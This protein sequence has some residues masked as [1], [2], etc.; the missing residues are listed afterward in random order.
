MKAYEITTRGID[1]LKLSE[2]QPA[3]LGARQVRVRIKASSLN[4][5]DLM[6]VLFGGMGGKLPLIPNSDG[7][8]E[9]IET[10]SEVTRCKTGDRVITT[11]FQH[12]LDGKITA[13][14]MQSALGG[15]LDGVLA[16]EIVVDEPGVVALPDYMSFEEGATLPCAALTAWHSMVVKGGLKAG[17]I[18]LLQG[19]GVSPCSA[20]N[21]PPCT[22]PGPS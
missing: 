6:T 20:C 14:V 22:E 13:D 12:W 19:T 21:S 7:C 3:A 9:I 17:D 10:G 11:F 2:R 1:A 16:E 8:G 5:R 18:V 4:Y 15:A